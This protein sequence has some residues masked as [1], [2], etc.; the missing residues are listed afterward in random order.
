MPYVTHMF[1]LATGF[2]RALRMSLRAQRGTNRERPLKLV[3]GQP[4]RTN[5]TGDSFRRAFGESAPFEPPG[6]DSAV[7]V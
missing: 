5:Y 4:S 2:A 1:E 3:D 7:A 6:D